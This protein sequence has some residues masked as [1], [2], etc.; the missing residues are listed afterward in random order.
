MPTT[1]PDPL[2]LHEG[3]P[4]DGLV[5]ADERR[6]INERVAKLVEA[7]A[8]IKQVRI[9]CGVAQRDVA[10]AM[11]VSPSSVAQLEGRDIATVQFGT[12]GRYFAALGYRVH[13]ELEPVDA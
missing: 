12:L 11:G 3:H 8:M 7:D 6:R 4:F 9:A 13:I 2:E 1:K 10:A 5:D